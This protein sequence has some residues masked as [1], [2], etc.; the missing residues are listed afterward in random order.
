MDIDTQIDLT[1]NVVNTYSSYTHEVLQQAT[2]LISKIQV[3]P[4]ET[5][6][7][8]ENLKDAINHL[9]SEKLPLYKIVGDNVDLEVHARIQ[10]KDHGNKSLHWTHQF[11]ERAR[12][13]SSI[14]TK[15]TIKKVDGKDS[16][17][18]RVAQHG[19]QLFEERGRNVQWAF[20]DGANQYDRLEGLRTEFADWHAK[21]TFYKSDIFVNTQSAAEREMEAHICAAF[22]EMLSM[23]T[24]EDSKPSMPNKDVPKTIRQKWLLDICKGIVDKYVFGVPD[25]NTLV[26]ET[27][28]LQNAMTAEFV[29]RAPTC[30]AKYIHHSG[31]VR[32][33]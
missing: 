22:M 33:R 24:L 32:Q 5:G 7:T 27:Q 31:R 12:I 14:P 15:Q 6:V 16:V 10:T 26:E 28:N 18:L 2:K 30:N 4:N 13:F 17:L 3:S 23:S 19:D 9:E 8:D 29:C 20:G 11:A 1:G 25:V 21:F